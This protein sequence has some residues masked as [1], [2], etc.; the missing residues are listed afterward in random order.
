LVLG[1]E[2]VILSLK[3]L[4]LQIN[5]KRKKQLGLL[6]VLMLIASVAEVV[7]IGA[8]V[9]FLGALANPE[10]ILQHERAQYFIN[11]FG[12]TESSQLLLP[13]F[14]V[15]AI[16]AILAGL[17]RIALLC[18]QTRLAAA[19]GADFSYQIYKYTLHQPYSKHIAQNSSEVIAAIS[20]KTD[21]VVGQNLLPT[22]NIAS[23]FI[24]L[25]M[26]LILMMIIH[27]AMTLGAIAGF[28]FIYSILFLVTKKKLHLNS[29]V[30]SQNTTKVVKFLQEGLG[31]IR[32]ILIDGT[33]STYSRAFQTVDVARRRGL[34]INQILSQSPRYGVEALG[35]VLIALLAYS[36][37][38]TESGLIGALP[39]L[40][41]V[42]IGA[43][44]IIPMLQHI[45]GSLSKIRGSRAILLDTLTML[46]LSMP[47][48]DKNLDR[49]TIP[50]QKVI[51]LNNLGFRYQKNA[52]WVL[53]E[54]NLKIL[55]GSMIGFI[56]TT[57][58][59]KSTLLDIIMALLQ[60]SKGSLEVDGVEI[61][62]NNYRGWQS[63]IA[64]IPQ[65]IYLSDSTI[66]ENI[67]FGLSKD[68][69]DH[70]KMIKMAQKA[71]IDETIQSWEMQY[72][73]VVGE[74]GVRLSGG[75]RQRIGI[76]RALYKNAD[77]LI[78]DEATSALDN[79]TEKAVM[80]AINEISKDV[81]ILIVAHRLSTLKNCDFIV[82]LE[83]G[84]AKYNQDLKKI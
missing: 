40:G 25:N 36:L 67:A 41:A 68:Q 12:I 61:N 72:D 45:Y 28:A 11:Y 58:S 27:F 83:N 29:H 50:F 20:T 48:Y 60:P 18:V 4:W 52:P 7:S 23:S 42:A 47:K 81:T 1:E 74:R 32:D 39:M 16:A 56:G 73:T 62:E 76:A 21:Q 17:T 69:I 9:P 22:L 15:F 57:G 38:I 19:I 77:V 43:Q 71:H 46:E 31:G 14:L 30:I 33:Q 63:H 54:I 2:S 44:R 8:V 10:V 70:K 26:I 5:T 51:Q 55:K 78:F 49:Q 79:V 64:H 80:D 66:A 53:T 84:K 24:M 75:Q 34:A 13:F 82:E 59:G 37:S 35:M 3:R 65:T 6:I